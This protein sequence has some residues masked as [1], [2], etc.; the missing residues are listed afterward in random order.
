MVALDEEQLDDQPAVLVQFLRVGV[1]D[2]PVGRGHRA[3]VGDLPVDLDGADAA[4]PPGKQV[5][6]VA[7]ARDVHARPVRGLEDRLSLQ[8]LHVPSVQNEGELFHPIPP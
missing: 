8:S 5:L 4:V 2:H 7:E 1:H 6:V 3:G